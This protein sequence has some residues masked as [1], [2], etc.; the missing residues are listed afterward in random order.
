MVLAGM[1]RP[2]ENLV[3]FARSEALVAQM[4]GQAGELAQ[5]GSESLGLCRLAA[6]DALLQVQRIAD[7]DAG[8]IEAAGEPGQGAQVFAAAAAA[9]EGQHR[10][11]GQAQFIGDGYADAAVADVEPEIAGWTSGGHVY[12]FRTSG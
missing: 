9:L 3:G 8:H 4:D 1:A 11:R 10:L 12:L 7:D 6:F 2:I 5:F